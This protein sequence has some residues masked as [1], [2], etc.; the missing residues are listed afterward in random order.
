MNIPAIYLADGVKTEF[1]EFDNLTTIQRDALTVSEATIIYNIDVKKFQKHNGTEWVN[2]V[3]TDGYLDLTTDQT[4]GGEKTFTEY[5]RFTDGADGRI[6][7]GQNNYITSNGTDL[8]LQTSG[9]FIA[10]VGGNHLI[11]DSKGFNFAPDSGTTK[12]QYL[13]SDNLTAQREVQFQDK[14]GTVA[15]LDDVSNYD[16]TG[17]LKDADTLSLVTPTNKLLTEDDVSGVGIVVNGVIEEGNVDAVSGGVVFDSQLPLLDKT[18]WSNFRINTW[19]NDDEKGGTHIYS[20]YGLGIKTDTNISSGNVVEFNSVRVFLGTDKFYSPVKVRVYVGDYRG[21]STP[22][23][24]NIGTLLGETTIY[25]APINR[26]EE[27]TVQFDEIFSIAG[28]SD[29]VLS[30]FFSTENDNIKVLTTYS[31]TDNVD[32]TRN[33]MYYNL[34]GGDTAIWDAT[35]N[36]GAVPFF[37]TP[38][39]NFS[40]QPKKEDAD[41]SYMPLVTLPS[42]VYTTVGKQINL[43]YDG[44][45]NGIDGGANGLQNYTISITG[46]KGKSFQRMWQYTPV[47]GDIGNHTMTVL[48]ADKNNHLICTKDFNVVV[49]DGVVPA[50]VK[51][52]LMI[53]DS[54]TDPDQ[55]GQA[56][57]STLQTD[58]ASLGGSTPLFVGTQGI[59]PS[60]NEGRGGWY[61]E[62]FIST[63]F[64]ND[65]PF[66]N[67][68]TLE[69]DI[70]NYRTAVLGLGA[71]D[72]IDIVT[73]FC[74]VNDVLQFQKITSKEKLDEVISYIKILV[75]AF[76]L[77]N[78]GTKIII[79]LPT[80]SGN[81]LNGYGD[82]YGSVYYYSDY[83]KGIFLLRLAI[84]EAFDNAAYNAN[85]EVGVS[86]L[87]VDRYFGYDRTTRAVSDRITETQEFHNNALHPFTE[88]FQQIADGY[89][90]QIVKEL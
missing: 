21:A 87:V 20:A 22:K 72:Y 46:S 30:V 82:N 5:T 47:F 54:L 86:G 18:D 61:Y 59:A 32:N 64:S 3:E 28:A 68:G 42:N 89:Y 43:Y 84:I 13:L 19:L 90:P 51:K 77:D 44:F 16:D 17:V 57:T 88:G 52:I 40:I 85:V 29:V 2:L 78:A 71:T 27:F 7:I 74:G 37:S 73:M 10:S 70:T 25:N 4:I 15:Y 34:T 11:V 58:L 56:T 48:I 50:S 63:G 24:P 39:T 14:N 79:A 23:V 8:T 76:L 62:Q 9:R 26:V 1:V 36:L 60:Q 67:F 69:V 49:N 65:N 80:I 53:G 83:K 41:L 6:Y 38:P 75:D 12:R 66:W 31:K 45:V 81:T 55:L 33:G 35:F